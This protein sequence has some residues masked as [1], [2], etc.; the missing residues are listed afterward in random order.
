MICAR[1]IDLMCNMT[2]E[3]DSKRLDPR[4]RMD[5]TTVP[6]FFR[7]L[8][9]FNMILI[10]RIMIFIIKKYS[11]GRPDLSLFFTVLGLNV[12]KIIGDSICVII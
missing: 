9:L 6:C 12:I 4:H 10:L 2:H 8:I 1:S 7:L 11:G 5:A 3:A